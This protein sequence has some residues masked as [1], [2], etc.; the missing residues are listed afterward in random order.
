MNLNLTGAQFQKLNKGIVDAYDQPTFAMMLRFQL[1]LRLDV[2]ANVNAPFDQVVFNTIQ[3]S[4]AEGWTSELVL[5]AAAFRPRN[6]AL[7]EVATK[8]GVTAAVTEGKTGTFLESLVN[9]AEGIPDLVQVLD[10]MTRLQRKVCR[11]EI[12]GAARGTGFLVGPDLVLTNH[13]VVAKVLGS[14]SQVKVRFDYWHREALGQ[15]PGGQAFAVEAIP[16]VSPPTAAELEGRESAPPPGT[17]SLDFALLKIAGAPG[18][19]MVNIVQSDGAGAV[20]FTPKP[21]D[22]VVASDPPSM[23][24]ADQALFILQHPEGKPLSIAWNAPGVLAVNP[25]GTRVKYRNNTLPGSSG[26]PCFN[27]NF[28]IVALH[29]S[30][31][32]QKTGAAASSL[33]NEGIPIK[34][35]ME[36]L[37]ASGD[38]VAFRPRAEV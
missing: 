6:G 5:E 26:S 18:D 11:I 37:N 19:Q 12:N 9:P 38:D 24:E 27:G 15:A 33:R 16:C 7:Y 34:A 4:E 23:P 17:E 2:F 3:R 22:W 29:H 36:A 8:L 1:G 35:V 13:H 21:R 30:G 31:N 32:L 25:E 20:E 28:Q 10:A 14:P